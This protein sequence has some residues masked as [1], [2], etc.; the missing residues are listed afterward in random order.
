MSIEASL[1][2]QNVNR[3]YHDHHR[4]LVTWL[5]RKLGCT[6]NAADLAHDAFLRLL[7]LPDLAAIDTPRAF[8]TIT[9][10]HLMIDQARRRKL[11][12]AYLEA[13]ALIQDGNCV[14][15]PADCQE[16]IETLLAITRLLEGLPE[17]ARRAFLL[18]RLEEASHTDIAA[19]L[20]ISVSMVKKYIARAMVHCYQLMH[21]GAR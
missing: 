11:E 6:H 20:G 13:L 17:K 18:S 9:A 5:C 7:S 12:R 4:W 1:P 2:L 14:P 8:L 16:A 15:S 19:V 3:I 10:T 21:G